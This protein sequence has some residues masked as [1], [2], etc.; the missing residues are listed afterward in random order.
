MLQGLPGCSLFWRM[1][2]D[3]LS[4]LAK[5]NLPGTAKSSR[6]KN[7]KAG[8]QEYQPLVFD[9]TA[10]SYPCA[11]SLQQKGKSPARNRKATELQGRARRLEALFR[12]T[13][14]SMT[15]PFWHSHLAINRRETAWAKSCSRATATLL[16]HQ[17]ASH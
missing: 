2:K 3:A 9:I 6:A 15:L 17:P 5:A 14:K 7:K 16:P 1:L 11:R 13:K 4:I 10:L 12:R 8:M